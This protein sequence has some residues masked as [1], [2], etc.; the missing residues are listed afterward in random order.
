VL[1]CRPQSFLWGETINPTT[2]HAACH[3]HLFPTPHAFPPV[4]VPLP[5][6]HLQC[7]PISLKVRPYWQHQAAL[8]F[9]VSGSIQLTLCGVYILWRGAVCFAEPTT[10]M[11]EI[12][13]IQPT[14]SQCTG[15]GC[16]GHCFAAPLLFPLQACFGMHLRAVSPPSCHPSNPPCVALVVETLNPAV[17]IL[18]ARVWSSCGG[19]SCLAATCTPTLCCF[20]AAAGCSPGG[21]ASPRALNPIQLGCLNC[22]AGL[23]QAGCSSTDPRPS[24]GADSVLA[25]PSYS[26]PCYCGHWA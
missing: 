9:E 14:S 8:L 10:H 6:L 19:F 4:G 24:L 2:Q 20:A 17:D 23:Q 12:V 22:F 16:A 13:S 3:P 1:E 25:P 7:H 26:G 21:W 18:C 11:L 5:G 15:K